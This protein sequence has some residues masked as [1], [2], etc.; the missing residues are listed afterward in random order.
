[1]LLRG[2]SEF[3]TCRGVGVVIAVVVVVVVAVV[4]VFRL[5]E[6]VKSITEGEEDDLGPGFRL[7]VVEI[8]DIVVISA[9]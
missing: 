3:T 7:G 6:V 8:P 4:V 2:L 5:V 9:G 1:V